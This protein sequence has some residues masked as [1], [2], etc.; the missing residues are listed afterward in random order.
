MTITLDPRTTVSGVNE[1]LSLREQ[2]DAATA[3]VE[4]LAPQVVENAEFQDGRLLR[5]PYYEARVRN[6]PLG[7]LYHLATWEAEGSAAPTPDYL[8][9]PAERCPL[10][11]HRWCSLPLD[12]RV[13]T[14]YTREPHRSWHTFLGTWLLLATDDNTETATFIA[15][16]EAA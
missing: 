1:L 16:E 3:R 5:L 15:I 10:H 2:I 11:R 13:K 14:R 4:A 12:Q 6:A 8:A 7:T 9:H